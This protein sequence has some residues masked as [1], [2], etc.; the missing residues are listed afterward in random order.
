MPSGEK[1]LEGTP[2]SRFQNNCQHRDNMLGCVFKNGMFSN[3]M[4]FTVAFLQL[5][6][7]SGTSFNKRI[8]ELL[9]YQCPD[10]RY[11]ESAYIYLWADAIGVST[12]VGR[13]IRLF[14]KSI[15]HDVFHLCPSFLKRRPFDL[16]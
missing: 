16:V 5:S 8:E 2:Q 3:L 13:M 9:V 4:Q 10:E 6:M 7:L 1:H 12:C 15:Q 14:D 11:H